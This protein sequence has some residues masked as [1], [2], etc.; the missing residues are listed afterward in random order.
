MNKHWC[1]MG[2]TRRVIRL[3][4]RRRSTVTLH[5]VF[6]I[7]YTV[8]PHY[9]YG[10]SSWSGIHVYHRYIARWSSAQA[11]MAHF[12]KDAPNSEDYNRS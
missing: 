7:G 12:M 5:D 8:N 4:Y 10:S 9:L 1:I 11:Y 6:R 3:I 2:N